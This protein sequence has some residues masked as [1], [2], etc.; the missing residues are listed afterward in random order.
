[1]KNELESPF[2]FL[3]E[4]QF[5]KPGTLCQNVANETVSDIRRGYDL[6]GQK[7]WY[8][9]ILVSKL[10][11]VPDGGA[12]DPAT[13]MVADKGEKGKSVA[14]P[15]K[16]HG[17]GTP[18]KQGPEYFSTPSSQVF[19]LADAEPADYPLIRNILLCPP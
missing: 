2:F 1:M 6:A 14:V 7:I 3:S 12:A 18:A 17:H 8:G 4:M 16:I 15:G 10:V 5:P 9:D 19:V 11:R 13:T